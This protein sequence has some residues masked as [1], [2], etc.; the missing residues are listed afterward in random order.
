[1]NDLA[2]ENQLCFPLYA[3]SY[4][5]F[6]VSESLLTNSFDGYFN[7]AGCCF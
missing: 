3:A 1:M 7:I 6:F 2:L 4:H 5:S